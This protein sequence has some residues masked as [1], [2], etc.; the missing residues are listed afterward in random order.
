MGGVV[1]ASVIAFPES[2]SIEQIE[3]SSRRINDSFRMRRQAPRTFRRT[4]TL[5]VLIMLAPGAVSTDTPADDTTTTTTDTSTTIQCATGWT[6]QQVKEIPQDW[7]DDGYC[8]CP[9][10]GADEPNTGACSGSQAWPGIVL[11]SAPVS[12]EEEEDRYVYLW[13]ERGSL[14]EGRLFLCSNDFR[15]QPYFFFF[16]T[17]DLSMPRAARVETASVAPFGWDL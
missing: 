4:A 15:F 7:I 2:S 3:S 5:F 8:D 9:F 17:S 10:D 16:S 1:I 6:N 11:P 14:S 13:G 12:E